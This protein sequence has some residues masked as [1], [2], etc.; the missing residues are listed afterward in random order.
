MV[1][2]VRTRRGL[3]IE[4]SFTNQPLFPICTSL[5]CFLSHPGLQA[6]GVFLSYLPEYVEEPG[7][8]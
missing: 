6:G 8:C 5:F 2:G 4:Q 3:L 7:V 1:F